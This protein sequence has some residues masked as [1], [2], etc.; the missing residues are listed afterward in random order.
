MSWAP[1]LKVPK[2]CNLFQ[3]TSLN[4]KNAIAYQKMSKQ[5]NFIR[6]VYENMQRGD[7]VYVR[8][9]DDYNTPLN[10]VGTCT[11]RNFN[12]YAA[13]FELHNED[14]EVTRTFP[15]FSPLLMNVEIKNREEVL[16][17]N[18]AQRQSDKKSAKKKEQSRQER[19]ERRQYLRSVKG[20]KWRTFLVMSYSLLFMMWWFLIWRVSL[21]GILCH[22]Y[23]NPLFIL[24]M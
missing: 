15:F 10:M 5:W 14:Q 19:L 9:T 1:V 4:L 23:S 17:V 8:W 11:R 12:S 2:T 22:T 16:A 13:R 24:K 6:P 18:K 3:N 21:N 20:E 7:V